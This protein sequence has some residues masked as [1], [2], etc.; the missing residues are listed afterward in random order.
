MVERV[1]FSGK[2]KRKKYFGIFCDIILTGFSLIFIGSYYFAVLE[3]KFKA[4][5]SSYMGRNLIFLTLLW[6][7]NSVCICNLTQYLF[8]KALTSVGYLWMV[9]KKSTPKQVTKISLCLT[10]LFCSLLTISK[11][12]D[13][14][15][16][17]V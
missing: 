13:N 3:Y 4:P 16:T 17:T 2:G 11:C 12:T 8:E 15:C 9:T 6:K 7:S 10:R 5:S 14:C 1:P